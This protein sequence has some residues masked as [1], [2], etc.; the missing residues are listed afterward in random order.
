MQYKIGIFGSAEEFD[1]SLIIKVK[2]LGKLL[3]QKKVIVIT[4]AASG[5]PYIASYEAFKNG[6]EIWGYSYEQNVENIRKRMPDH[7]LS[8]YKKLIYIPRSFSFASDIQ[9][10]KKYRNVTSTATCDAGIIIAGRWGTMNEFTNLYDMGKV[11]GVLT[12]TGG[13]ADEL[14]KLNKKIHKKSKAKILFNDSPAELVK[15]VLHELS[16]KT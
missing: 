2:E 15:G 7:D 13:I 12:G 5:F 6:A 3:G 11:I 16:E 14:P 10:S 8:I 1:K 9:V 4:G